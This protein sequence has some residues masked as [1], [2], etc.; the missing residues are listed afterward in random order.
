MIMTTNTVN[1]DMMSLS[2]LKK[3]NKKYTKKAM[4]VNHRSLLAVQFV[5][6]M[7]IIQTFIKLNYCKVCC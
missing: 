4:E 5:C 7:I 1:V 2:K 6:R 3:A